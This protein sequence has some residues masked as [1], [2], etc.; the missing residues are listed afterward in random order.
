MA[1]INN[2]FGGGSRT[3]P[4]EPQPVTW[5]ASASGETPIGQ[6][7]HTLREV[8]KQH[9]QFLDRVQTV[10]SQFTPDGLHQQLKG[11]A[12]S[13]AGNRAID[14]AERLAADV[15]E[16][17]DEDYAR[18]LQGLS[19]PGDAAQE[20][21]N[22]RAIDRAGRQLA[23]LPE[24]QRVGAASK[25]VAEVDRDTLGALVAELPSFGVD[26]AVVEQAAVR[27]V[28]ELGEAVARRTKAHQSAA[29]IRNDARRMRDCVNDGRKLQ[30][31][32]VNP[33]AY[34]PG[35]AQ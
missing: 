9:G 23:A 2:E 14:A 24:G 29:I 6:A 10:A 16:R 30:V 22:Q 20:L 15:A 34:D 25:L 11:F 32:L 5:N 3:T 13:A 31:P 35:L 28:P 27:A 17:A 1:Y 26:A 8:E 18:A 19:T 7:Y 33:A 21:R 4:A 12:D